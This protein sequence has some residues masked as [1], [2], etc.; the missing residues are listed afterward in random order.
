MDVC[1]V[2]VD[3]YLKDCLHINNNTS[4]YIY[5]HT[6]QNIYIQLYARWGTEKNGNKVEYLRNSTYDHPT[7][8][9]IRLQSFM[10]QTSRTGRLISL[11]YICT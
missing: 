5:I 11:E 8:E 4:I 2:G 3:V 10:K 9:P 7:V 6:I 1:I